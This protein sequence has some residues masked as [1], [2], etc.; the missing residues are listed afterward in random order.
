MMGMARLFHR[1]WK[2]E[3]GIS[4]V[5]YALLLALIAA[6]V[7]VAA[8]ALGDAVETEIQDAANCISGTD[9]G[10]DCVPTP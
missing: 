3:S 6:G 10:T 9:P 7:A 4:S 8:A 5:E 2:D 1:L